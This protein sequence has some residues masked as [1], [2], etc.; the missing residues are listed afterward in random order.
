MTKGNVKT[1]ESSH[2]RTRRCGEGEGVGSGLAQGVVG[3]EAHV[4]AC[5]EITIQQGNTRQQ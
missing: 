3:G 1:E 4:V 5:D 2:C